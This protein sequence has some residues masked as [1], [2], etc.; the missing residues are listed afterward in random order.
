MV[1]PVGTNVHLLA[2]PRTREAIAIDTAIPSVAWVTGELAERS[3]TLKLIVTTHGHWD[4]F[5]DKAA[6]AAQTGA[7]GAVTRVNNQ[8]LRELAV[9]A[10]QIRNK[11]GSDS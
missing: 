5:G 9:N 2:D 1:G 8:R 10:A 7:P 4:H 11:Y 3:W 6:V